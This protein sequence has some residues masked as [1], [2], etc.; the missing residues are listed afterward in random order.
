MSITF[1]NIMNLNKILTSVLVAGVGSFVIPSLSTGF[2]AKLNE[3][4][5]TGA[6]N[7]W[8]YTIGSLAP[9]VAVG[10]MWVGVTM[11]AI[12]SFK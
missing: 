3:T 11:Y 9:A 7:R 6:D 1:L 2:I 4:Y 8:V 12:K 10:G 5:P